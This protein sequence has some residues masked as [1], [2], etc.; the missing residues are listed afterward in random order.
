[1]TTQPADLDDLPDLLTVDE[2]RQILRV[3]RNQLYEA[4]RNGEVPHLRIGKSIRIPKRWIEQQ[5]DPPT[6]DDPAGEAG[7][8]AKLSTWRDETGGRPPDAA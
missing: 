3:G 8:V 1:M 5:C 4:C 7:P 6:S 2:A